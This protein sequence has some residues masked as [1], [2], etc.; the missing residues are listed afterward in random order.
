MNFIGQPIWGLS[1]NTAALAERGDEA[2][3]TRTAE[4]QD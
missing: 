4:E 1:M 2:H 3:S